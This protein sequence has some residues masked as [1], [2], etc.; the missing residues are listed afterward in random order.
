V[1]GGAEMGAYATAFPGGTT[2]DE[3]GA[4]ALSEQYGFPVQATPG[5]SAAEMLDAAEQGAL[6]VLWSSG[7]NFLEVLPDPHRVE[8]ALARVPL[9]VHQDIIVSS[10]MLVDGDTVLL[11]PAATRYEQ[12]GGGT[13]TTTERR[14]AFSPEIRGPRPGV[15]RSEWEIFGDVARRVD[16]ERAGLATFESGEAIREEIARVVPSYAGIEQLEK[17]GDAV[18]WGGAHLCEGGEFPTP[19]GRGAFTAVAPVDTT[20]GP[21][22]LRLSTRRGKQFN[23]IVFADRDPLTGARRDSVFVSAVD[24]ERLGLRDG[25]RVMVRSDH[26]EMPAKAF[27]TEIAPGNVQVLFPEGNVLL[28]SGRREPLSHVPDY[29]AMVEVVP[30]SA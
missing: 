9:R 22:R 5:L 18:Q 14:I 6:D 17:T 27:V 23:T 16:P 4:A 12:K 13:E 15:A 10:Q 11:L 2:I 24:A 25:D 7:G 19:D 26:G 28:P 30:V 1:Q 8:H 3:A 20:L 29:T 21:N